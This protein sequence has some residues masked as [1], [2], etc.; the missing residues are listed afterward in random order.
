[1]VNF[2]VICDGFDYHTYYGNLTMNMVMVMVM[3]ISVVREPRY[4]GS[5]RGFAAGRLLLAP[6]LPQGAQPASLIQGLG[7]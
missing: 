7:V 6:F 4:W 2:T 5:L 3:M 1:M